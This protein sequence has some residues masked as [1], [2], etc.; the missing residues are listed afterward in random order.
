[1]IIRF[2]FYLAISIGFAALL[3]VAAPLAKAEHTLPEPRGISLEAGCFDADLIVAVIEAGA[4]RNSLWST[5][6]TTGQCFDLRPTPV[7]VYY[8]ATVDE[9]DWVSDGTIMMVLE[10]AT[11]SGRFAYTWVEKSRWMQ[12]FP[13]IDQDA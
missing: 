2:L 1:M 12:A 10:F 9:L 4:R 6:V 13:P 11:P 5:L 8:H 7:A 3:I